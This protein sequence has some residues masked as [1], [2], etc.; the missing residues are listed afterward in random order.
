ARGAEQEGRPPHAVLAAR[1]EGLRGLGRP[2]GGRG[3]RRVLL[4]ALLLGL[5]ACPKKKRSESLIGGLGT[6][7]AGGLATDL[8]ISPDGKIAAYLKEG[9]KPRLE[10]VP[11]TMRV[12]EL[13]VVPTAGGSPRKLGNGVSN[14][15]G[16]YLF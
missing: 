15:P 12:G 4:V 8:R 6:V 3:V 14:F 16:G 10:G 5:A 11:P 9:S 7:V 1:P 13:H 2:Q